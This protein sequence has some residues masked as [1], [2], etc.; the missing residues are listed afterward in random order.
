MN[1]RRT[2]FRTSGQDCIEN[3]VRDKKRAADGGDLGSARKLPEGSAKAGACACD[4]EKRHEVSESEAERDRDHGKV[5][6]R[7][8]GFNPEGKGE[9]RAAGRDDQRRKDTRKEMA[10]TPFE[11]SVHASAV[12]PVPKRNDTQQN[13]RASDSE[14]ESM[15]SEPKD[16]Q[17]PSYS[18]NSDISQRRSAPKCG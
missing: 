5:V 11:R 13:Q 3:T 4:N 17:R 18:R 12:V 16:A 9:R 6:R 10:A 7:Q 8:T 14:I 15:R 1:P 2:R